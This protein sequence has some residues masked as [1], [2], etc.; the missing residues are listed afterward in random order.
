MNKSMDKKFIVALAATI[1]LTVISGCGS[2]GSEEKPEAPK[3]SSKPS[4]QQRTIIPGAE[5]W[6]CKFFSGKSEK[7][8][9]STE[10]TTELLS[11]SEKNPGAMFAKN[12]KIYNAAMN[13]ARGSEDLRDGEVVAD[14]S[15]RVAAMQKACSTL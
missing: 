3:V 11:G 7:E 2:S 4:V 13:L 15:K 14:W 12:K 9:K 10:I 5:K 1:A 6:S 8:L